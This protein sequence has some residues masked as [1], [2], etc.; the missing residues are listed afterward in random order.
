MTLEP[1]TATA[2]RQQHVVD[3]YFDGINSERFDDVAALFAPDAELNAPGVPT[4]RGPAEIAPYFREVLRA[5]P[6]HHDEPVRVLHAD[7]AATVEIHYTG[8]LADGTPIEFDAVDLFDFDDQGRIAHLRTVYDSHLVRS[9][10]AKARGGDHRPVLITQIDHVDGEEDAFNAW[11]ERHA[12]EVLAVP[13]VQDVQ[14]YRAMDVQPTGAAPP[15]RRWVAI[16]HLK[17]DVPAILA[18]IVRRRRDGEWSPRV[19]IVDE[20]ISMAAF[21]P[22]RVDGRPIGA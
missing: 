3:A 18:E 5:Y 10:L 11:F 6:V 12:Q 19:S 20:T 8:E 1:A 9:R 21:A 16:Y 14:R 2:E 22:V 17:R 4:R 7:G 15:L 13:G